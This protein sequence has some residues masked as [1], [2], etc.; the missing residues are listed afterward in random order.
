M[1]AERFKQVTTSDLHQIINNAVPK[2]TKKATKFYVK[3]FNG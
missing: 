3:I 2:N 1:A